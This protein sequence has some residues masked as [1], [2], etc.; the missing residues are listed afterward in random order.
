MSLVAFR[1]HHRRPLPIGP[2]LVIRLESN[3]LPVSQLPSRLHKIIDGYSHSRSAKLDL[4]S[5]NVWP[6]SLGA[7]TSPKSISSSVCCCFRQ[8][9][10]QAV[11]NISARLVQN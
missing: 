1:A 3:H 9:E 6:L 8:A 2:N 5:E 7:R 4:D 10:R 11:Q